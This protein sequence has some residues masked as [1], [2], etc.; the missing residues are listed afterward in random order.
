MKTESTTPARPQHI[1]IITSPTGEEWYEAYGPLTKDRSKA[2][3]FFTNDLTLRTPQRFGRNGT[4]FW[5]SEKKAEAMAR[6]EYAGWTHRHEPI[7]A[8]LCSAD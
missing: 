3:E 1:T 6:K 5:E 2:T 8:A 7:T 4:A